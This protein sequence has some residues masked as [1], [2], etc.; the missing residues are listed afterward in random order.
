VT[1]TPFI[2]LPTRCFLWVSIILPRAALVFLPSSLHLPSSS[3][4]SFISKPPPPAP[5]PSIHPQQ[6]WQRCRLIAPSRRRPPPLTSDL[7][8]TPD[9]LANATTPTAQTLTLITRLCR[10]PPLIH[11]PVRRR[12]PRCCPA[13]PVAFATT[14]LQS[15]VE[16][17]LPSTMAFSN[18]RGNEV[19]RSIASAWKTF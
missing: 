12:C 9:L 15:E 18:P 7:L 3:S 6:R 14:S 10:H 5:P 13:P 8:Y 2:L 1:P 16:S 17:K 11:C 19:T 4:S